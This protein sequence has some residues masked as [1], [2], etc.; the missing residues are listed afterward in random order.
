MFVAENEYGGWGGGGLKRN[1]HG[2][3]K[4]GKGKDHQLDVRYAVYF[5]RPQDGPDPPVQLY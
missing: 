3:C 2:I 4:T 1:I 5:P